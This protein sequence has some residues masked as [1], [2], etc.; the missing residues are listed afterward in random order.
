[1][2]RLE[3]ERGLI[4]REDKNLKTLAFFREIN[5]IPPK[6]TKESQDFMEDDQGKIELVNNL[7]QAAKFA[8]DDNNQFS[9]TV[10]IIFSKSFLVYI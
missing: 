4:Q 7:K 2:T 6:S 9:F 3:I 10:G 8:L 1:V 5:N